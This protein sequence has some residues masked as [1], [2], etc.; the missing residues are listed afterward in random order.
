MSKQLYWVPNDKLINAFMKSYVPDYDEELEYHK[1]YYSK[2]FTK[3]CQYKSK[4]YYNDVKLMRKLEESIFKFQKRYYKHVKLPKYDASFRKIRLSDKPTIFLYWHQGV[5]ELP[6]LQQ[7]CYDRLKQQC[8]TDFNIV[9]LDYMSVKSY[10]KIPTDIE[11]AMLNEYMWLQHYVDYIRLSLLSKYEAIW[12]DLTIFV[13]DNLAAVNFDKSFW[14]IKCK[15]MFKD[16]WAKDV[17]PQMHKC[18][19][20]AMG[21]TSYYFFECM[22]RIIEYHFDKFGIAYSYYMM[23]YIAEYLYQTNRHIRKMFNNLDYNNEDVEIFANKR[24][25]GIEQI[26]EFWQMTT[27]THLFKI[28]KPISEDDDRQKVY[29]FLREIY[30]NDKK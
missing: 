7:L 15:D 4:E 8:G 11:Y 18:Q 2:G 30:E 19:I 17:I 3:N 27:N 29:D 10:I 16:T 21:G 24:M 14:S 28:L 23:Y 26:K 25:V 20:Y 13:R 9:L 12:F 1:W 6:P 5:N 22:K